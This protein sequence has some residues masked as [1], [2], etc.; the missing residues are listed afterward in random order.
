VI[1]VN[2]LPHREAA[3]KRRRE[4]F[5]ATLGLAAIAGLL[6]CGAV[7]SWYLTQIETQRGKNL[8]L[9]TEI[10][11]LEEQIKEISTLQAEITALRA[12]Q[13]AV[14]DLQG[15]RNLP[16]YLLTELVRQLP[17]GVYINSMKQD[18][19]S[20][21]ITGVAQSNERVSEL[22]RNFSNNSPYLS[23]PDLIEIT[24][25]SVA[26]SQRDQ[27]R[28]ANFSMRVALKRAN[29]PKDPSSAASSPL[30]AATVKPV[31]AVSA[32]KA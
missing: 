20:V 31:A 24:A 23:K 6:I 25:G 18:N 30:P 12:R 14:E 13:N 2:L 16:V 7:Y 21:Q 26:L 5:F 10:T 15:N 19:Q 9:K 1:L 8:F 32:A 11:R 17:D 4:A 29:D 22:L 28:V 3:R 27:R